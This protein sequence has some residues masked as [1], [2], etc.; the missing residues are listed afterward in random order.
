MNDYIEE[1][2]AS[3]GEEI[4]KNNTKTSTN[5]KLFNVDVH[6][7]KLS[8]D[9]SDIFHHIVAKLLFVMKRV[10]LDISTTIAFLF[11]RVTKSTKVDWVKLKRLLEYL[12]NTK[13]MK[14][15]IGMDGLS[16]MKTYV[17]ASYTV[18]P[19]MRGHSGGLITTGKGAI[20]N[21]IN[22]Q[23]LNTK[24]STEIELVAASDYIPW[25]VWIT[26]VLYEQG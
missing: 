18:H 21:K 11:T 26:K 8:E 9:K 6:S 2:I 19:Y 3:Y 13:N 15:I 7:I 23:K 16:I 24:S 14:R 17:D 25:T 1:Y 20:H 5:S 12:N 22:K 10:R 4:S